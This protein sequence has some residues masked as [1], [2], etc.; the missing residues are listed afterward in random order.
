MLPGHFPYTFN[1]SLMISKF[2]FILSLWERYNFHAKKSKCDWHCTSFQRSQ[3]NCYQ[4]IKVHNINHPYMGPYMQC[5]WKRRFSKTR[6]TL[7]DDDWMGKFKTISNSL[8]KE[9]LIF[10][11]SC[12]V[13]NFWLLISSWSDNY[14][15]LNK[16]SSFL[17]QINEQKAPINN[18]D[19]S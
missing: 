2:P 18:A 4:Y 9:I 13:S 17:Q 6:V 15:I 16:V 3:S 19:V 7:W 14:E 5:G 11:F 1:S 8:P 10:P 12:T